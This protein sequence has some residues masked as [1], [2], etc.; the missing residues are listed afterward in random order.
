MAVRFMSEVS[1]NHACDLG[2]C[3]DFIDVSAE[4]GCDAV[5]FQLFRVE[6]IFS[7]EILS[8]SEKHR[9]RK[10]WE[11][12]E[13]FIAPIAERCERRGLT[14]CCTPFHLGAVDVLKE[15]VGVFKIASYELLW[16]GLLEKVAR[17]AKPVVLSTGLSTL[18]EVQGAVETLRG[19]GAVDITLLHCISAYPTPPGEANLAAI[20]TIADATGCPVGWSDHT[21]SPGVLHRAIHKWEVPLIEFH[22]DLDGTGAEYAAGHCW[23]PYEIGALIREVR[24]AEIADGTG[25]KAP[26][27]SELPDRDWRA[28]PVDGLRPLR[29]IRRSWAA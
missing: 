17:T 7:S 5:K 24:A 8:R 16:T 28:D 3:L 10:R 1:S 2:R 23:L 26:T 27:P 4:I 13:G 19:A 14:F 9:A 18:D 6:E 25:I 21:V 11:L 20:K 12:P 22:L 29:A 15:H